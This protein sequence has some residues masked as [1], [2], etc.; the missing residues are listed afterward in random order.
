L[1]V[2]AS[3]V[4]G[5]GKRFLLYAHLTLTGRAPKVLK[6]LSEEQRDG[7]VIRKE[8]WDTA[9]L[10]PEPMEMITC[11]TPSGDWIGEEKTAKFLV[12]EMG[13]APELSDPDHSVCSTGFCAKENRWYGWS[14]RAIHGFGVGD[15]FEEWY[16]EGGVEGK[17]IETL[18]EARAAAKAFAE[19]VS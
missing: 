17:K 10:V 18:E 7:Y 4:L 14:H 13:I 15:K 16:P 5:A 12:E 19:S 8:M 9:G 2:R 3:Q 6:V 11:Y 1:I